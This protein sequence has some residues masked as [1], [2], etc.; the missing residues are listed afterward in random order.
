M[1]YEVKPGPWDPA[2]DKE[3]APWAPPEGD[4]RAAELVRALLSSR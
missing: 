4:P 3:M 2:T 1:I